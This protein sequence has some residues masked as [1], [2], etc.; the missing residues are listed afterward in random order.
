MKTNNHRLITNNQALNLSP[1]TDA[2]QPYASKLASKFNLPSFF[3]ISFLLTGIL[4]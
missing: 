4:S 1:M 3:L 2:V